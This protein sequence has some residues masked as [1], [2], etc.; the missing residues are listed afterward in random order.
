[1]MD[2]KRKKEGAKRSY[3]IAIIVIL[4]LAIL[5]SIIGTLF[6]LSK[7]RPQAVP[8]FLTGL[9][10][11]NTSQVNL[12]V[13]GTISINV[14][15][16]FINFG[17]IFV[18]AS[19]QVGNISSD[20]EEYF[21]K[22]VINATDNQTIINDPHNIINN[23]TIVVNLTANFQN[24]RNASDFLCGANQCPATNSARVQVKMKDK[25]AGSC[26]SGAQTTYTN[27]STDSTNL[28]VMLCTSLNYVDTADD[29]EVDY[30]LSIPH[31]VD[32]G[33]KTVTITYE[34]VAK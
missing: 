11:D 29:I 4:I 14:A 7:L 26:G 10:N 16:A 23:G 18:N 28:T 19:C 8:D 9:V 27:I 25:E 17:T 1:M 5:L 24:R 20:G 22:C 32:Q 30:N 34:A 33:A 21:P 31:D 2:K 15:D 13:T 6:A 3:E 12:T